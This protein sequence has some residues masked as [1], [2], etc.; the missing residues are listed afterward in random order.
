[1]PRRPTGGVGLVDGAPLLDTQV[2]PGPRGRRVVVM[3]P[4]HNY[5]ILSWR[6]IP[7]ASFVQG[8]PGSTTTAPNLPNCMSLASLA[9]SHQSCPLYGLR[10]AQNG[11]A[12]STRPQDREWETK[13]HELTS[14]LACS[15]HKGQCDVQPRRLAISNREQT[16]LS[17]IS[18]QIETM[19]CH[20]KMRHDLESPASRHTPT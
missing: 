10:L 5:F 17:C 6:F 12:A 9:L 13:R 14:L 18:M 20:E 16:A 4:S 11:M 15:S 7:P 8:P 3:S 1:M 2:P 19:P